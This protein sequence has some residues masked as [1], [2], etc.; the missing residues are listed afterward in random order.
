MELNF[1]VDSSLIKHFDRM[2][3]FVVLVM[4]ILEYD[5]SIIGA[6]FADIRDRDFHVISCRTRIARFQGPIK[7]ELSP[8]Q[9]D[10]GRFESTSSIGMS[11]LAEFG[12]K[13]DT[14]SR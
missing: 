9:F 8:S 10:K 12:F 6:D 14:L 11:Y 5:E 7:R 1:L 13:D 2:L 4:P 3:P